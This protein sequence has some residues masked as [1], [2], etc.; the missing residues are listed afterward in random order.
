MKPG[1]R[2]AQLLARRR[3]TARIPDRRPRPLRPAPQVTPRLIR[4]RSEETV[5]A[6]APGRATLTDK[7]ER[8]GMTEDNWS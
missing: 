4:S 3:N 1:A 2:D 8:S 6:E 7:E 5:V